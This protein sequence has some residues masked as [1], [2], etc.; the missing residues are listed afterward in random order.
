MSQTKTRKG[1]EH[2]PAD[3]PDREGAD[4]PAHPPADF[5]AAIEELERLV[6]SMEGGALSLEASLAAY[7]RGVVL[8]RFCQERLGAAEQQVRILEADVLRAVQPVDED[9]D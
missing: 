9:D 2:A 5:E 6:A 8:T 4:A 1:A 3:V 7:Q